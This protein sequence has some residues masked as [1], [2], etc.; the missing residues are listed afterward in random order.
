MNAKP[1]RRIGTRT[2]RPMP[3]LARCRSRQKLVLTRRTCGA[4]LVFTNEAFTCRT[5]PWDGFADRHPGSAAT[6]PDGNVIVDRGT[7]GARSVMLRAPCGNLG[8][9]QATGADV[10]PAAE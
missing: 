5:R 6:V 9:L 2:V 8:R 3:G 1:G 7:N 4:R 10:A